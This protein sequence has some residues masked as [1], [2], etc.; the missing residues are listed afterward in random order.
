MRA[1]TQGNYQTMPSVRQQGSCM[2]RYTTIRDAL[3]FAPGLNIHLDVIIPSELLDFI[4]IVQKEQGH[5]ARTEFD[6]LCHIPALFSVKQAVSS[7][8]QETPL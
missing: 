6:K 7:N 5:L 8:A 2:S 1:Q 4:M 3:S